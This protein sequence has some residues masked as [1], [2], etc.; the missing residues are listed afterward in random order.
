MKRNEP[1]LVEKLFKPLKALTEF[2]KRF[3]NKGTGGSVDANY[4]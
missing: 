4:T 1:T 2:T 3:T